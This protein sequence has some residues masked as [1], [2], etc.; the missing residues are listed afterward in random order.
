MIKER[1]YP[2]SEGKFKELI[3]P[4]IKKR[5]Q[6][7]GRPTKVGHYKFFCSVLYVLRIGIS[8]QELPSGSVGS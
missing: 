4:V 6:K 3:E 2:I 1:K 8:W 5:L 7:S